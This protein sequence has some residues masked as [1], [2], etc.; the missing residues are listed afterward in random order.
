MAPSGARGALATETRI[1]VWKY[2]GK[3]TQKEA[4]T[5]MAPSGAGGALATET[6]LDVWKYAGKVRHRRRR[7]RLWPPAVRE[8]PLPARQG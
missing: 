3:V 2:V 7:A 5:F 8:V 6:R 4:S 1:D